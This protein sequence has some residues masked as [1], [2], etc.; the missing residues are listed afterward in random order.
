M[1]KV[2]KKEVK[3]IVWDSKLDK[4]IIKFK[5]DA[6]T[7]KNV[8]ICMVT[9]NKKNQ[10]ETLILN[11]GGNNKIFILAFLEGI[12]RTNPGILKSLALDMLTM[13]K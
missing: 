4:E 1:A 3:K 9:T 8:S 11:H 6:L 10:T 2:V 12:K 7:N 5:K 13:L